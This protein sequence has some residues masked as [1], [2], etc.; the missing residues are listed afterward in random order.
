MNGRLSSIACVASTWNKVYEAPVGESATVVL[1]IVNHNTNNASEPARVDIALTTVAGTPGTTDFLEKLTEV[2]NVSFQ[3]S[4]IVI[5]NGNALYVRPDVSNVTAI[6][7]GF[8]E[9]DE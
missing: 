8:T 7:Y 6:V 2:Y 3:Q 1:H 5:S 9:I 4:G